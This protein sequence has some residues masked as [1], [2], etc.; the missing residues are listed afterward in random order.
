MLY[1]LLNSASSVC[2]G[3][4]ERGSASE[5]QAGALSFPGPSLK[6]C[7]PIPWWVALLERIGLF[8]LL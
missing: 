3:I 8:A 5:I 1:F 7:L 6:L 4:F 2:L